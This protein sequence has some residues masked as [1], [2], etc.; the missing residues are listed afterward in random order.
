MSGGIPRGRSP[1]LADKNAYT[2][3][4]QFLDLRLVV[5]Q[6]RRDV[7]VLRGSIV[8]AELS[9]NDIADLFGPTGVGKTN[10]R[11]EGWLI[12][13]GNNGTTDFTALVPAGLTPITKLVDPTAIGT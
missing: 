7:D 1:Q 2:N 12:S 6:L 4:T 11:F 8:L 13:N 10:K 9:A 3:Q 5:E